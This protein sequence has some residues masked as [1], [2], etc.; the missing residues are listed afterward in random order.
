MEITTGY[1]LA[2]VRTKVVGKALKTGRLFL[3]VPDYQCSTVPTK[4]ATRLRPCCIPKPHS[5][6]FERKP[7][8]ITSYCDPNRRFD[9][10]A[11]A[12]LGSSD[13]A[14]NLCAKL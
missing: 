11:A 6:G 12:S 2:L 3:C 13:H 1:D 8:P 9:V 4:M 10:W 7:C 5:A 14:P